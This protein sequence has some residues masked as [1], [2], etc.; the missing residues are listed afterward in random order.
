MAL[1]RILVLAGLILWALGGLQ[2]CSEDKSSDIDLAP[3][4]QGYVEKGDLPQLKARGTLRILSPHQAL[5]AH[6]PRKGFP[7]TLERELVETFAKSVGLR[8]VWSTVERHD[9]L[10]PFL[11]E[12]KG[13]LIAANFTVTSDRKER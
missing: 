12:G 2:A 3:A 4:G 13:D 11:L 10:I 5:V 9:Q 7:L 1:F 8:P 6:L